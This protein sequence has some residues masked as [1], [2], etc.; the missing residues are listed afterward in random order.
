MPHLGRR[1]PSDAVRPVFNVADLGGGEVELTLYGDVMEDDR[2]D[3]WTGER[4]DRPAITSES[5]NERFPELRSASH[6]TVRLNSTG[7]DAFAGIA[8]YNVLRSVPARVTVRIDGV[9]ASAASVIACAGDEVVAQPGSIFMAHEASLALFGL[10]STSDIALI[11]RELDAVN[12]SIRDAYARKCGKPDDE[13]AE[14][15]AAE[16][17]LVGEEIVDA[18]FAD[19]YESGDEPETVEEDGDG[20]LTVAGIRHDVSAFRH[21]P[22]D[23]AERVAA[24]ARTAR[25]SFGGAAASKHDSRITT[26]EP[27][28]AP[29]AVAHTEEPPQA[30]TERGEGPMDLTELQ[31]QHPDL[32]DEIRTAAARAERERLAA[33]DEIA[34]GIPAD[35]V[36][37]AKYTNPVS[38]QELAFA[39]LKA[40]RAAAA[41]YVADAAADADE[42]GAG[43]VAAVPAEPDDPQEQGEAAAAEAFAKAVELVNAMNSKEVR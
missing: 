19:T 24:S 7:G 17:W 41:A 28:A 22:A 18:G 9:A 29:A 10:Y 21:V 14:I 25:A 16:T 40:E 33:I 12:R 8:I 32:V 31:A 42:S 36:E 35:M 30:A 43:D 38:A 1:R 20:E 26:Q 27:P 4:T 11:G 23:L 34:S 5:I 39:A 37:A 15:M 2:R 13:L 3:P 6:I